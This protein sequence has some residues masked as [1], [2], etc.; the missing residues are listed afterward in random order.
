MRQLA[1][2]LCLGLAPATALAQQSPDPSTLDEAQREELGRLFTR[3]QTAYEAQNYL[4]AIEAL[5]AAH[6]IFGEPNILYRI[7]D[8][9][10]NLGDLDRAAQYYREYVEAAPNASDAGLVRRRIADLERRSKELAAQLEPTKPERAALLLDTNPAG[11][12][13]RL[14]DRAVDGAT[15]V[16]VEL[17]PGNHRVELQ[18]DGFDS[19]VRDIRIDAGETIS[20]VYQLS[21]KQAPP[22][23]RRSPW[24]WVLA[25]AGIASAGTSVGF[26]LGA[27][28]ANNRVSQ[29]DTERVQAYQAGNDVPARPDGYD[30]DTRNAVVFRNV[31]FVAAGVGAAAL[32][33]GGLWL[34]LRKHPKQNVAVGLTP[35]GIS[36]S[37]FF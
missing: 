35:T 9:Y 15:P 2:V 5:R 14:D 34:I 11:A 30:R 25:G 19:V 20:L 17:A 22:P 3:A 6:D 29:W 8:A 31:G 28:A 13:V 1:M 32:I 33:T 36:A 26:L 16:R 23:P 24:P 4:E 27:Q 21:E 37:V 10:E 12:N 7:G 18:R